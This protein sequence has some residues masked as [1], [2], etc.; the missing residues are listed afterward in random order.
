[1]FDYFDERLTRYSVLL[2]KNAPLF[3]G[4]P[5]STPIVTPSEPQTIFSLEKVFVSHLE[6]II[7][8]EVEIL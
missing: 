6:L 1:M 2:N 5:F 8:S 7:K 4:N 3:R